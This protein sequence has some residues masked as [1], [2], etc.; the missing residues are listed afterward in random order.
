MLEQVR[1]FLAYL[2]SERGTSVNTSSAYRSDLIQL[3]EYIDNQHKSV[4][5]WPSVDK[6]IV[7][8]YV[9]FLNQRDYMSATKR[10]KLACLKSFFSFLFDEAVIKLDPTEYFN[11]PRAGNTLPKSLSEDEIKIL[12]EEIAKAKSPE[13]IRDY[14]MVEILYATGMRVS[15]L[16][17]ITLGDINLREN[18]IRCTGKG[19]KERLVNIH[20]SASGLLEYYIST[21]RPT[22]IKPGI[23]R[24]NS[25][26]HVFLSLRGNKLTRQGFWSILK[27]YAKTAGLET[28]L[29]PHVLRHTFATHMLNGG[30][31]LRYIQELLGHSSIATTQIYTHIAQTQLQDSYDKAHPRANWL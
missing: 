14:T 29:T 11:V 18:Y 31:P 23:Y 19:S 5:S 2:E 25:V 21:I 27:K 28:N 13:S 17:S 15:E 22:L 4:K 8:D 26:Q 12:F 6:A 3:V 7:T 1:S 9:S 20:Q 24:S 10:R 30:A 16:I